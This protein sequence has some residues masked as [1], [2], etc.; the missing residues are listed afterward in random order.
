[1]DGAED[2]SQPIRVLVVDDHP[3][4]RAGV[5]GMLAS[6]ADFDVVGEASDGEEAL[7]QVEALNPDV[8]LMDLRMPRVDGVEATQADS[9]TASRSPGTRPH[10]LRHRRGH[11]PGGRGR[12]R[13]LPPQ[14]LSP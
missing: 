13:R 12:R 11:R 8:V 14:G 6:H 2:M 4:V 5:Q 9:G 7:S 10:H 1:M 3:V